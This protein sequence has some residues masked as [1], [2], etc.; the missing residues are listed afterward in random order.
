M[1]FKI[2]LSENVSLLL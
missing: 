2:I 1:L